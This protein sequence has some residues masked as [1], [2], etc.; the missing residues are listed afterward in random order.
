[1]KNNLL[2]NLLEK[3]S[4]EKHSPQLWILVDPDKSDRTKLQ[5]VAIAAQSAG[6]DCFL[7]GSSL[8][9]NS[10]IDETVAVLKANCEIPVLLFPGARTQLAKNADGIL[11]LTL[12]SSRNPRWLID[13]QV[14]AAPQVYRSC[15]PT[16]PVGYLLIESGEQTSVGFFSSTPPIPRAKADIAIAHSLAAQYMGMRAVY[17]EA[18]SGAKSPVPVEMLRAVAAKIDVPLIVGG[19]IRTLEDAVE[20][21][22][23]ADAI[24]IGNH[25]EN[26]D[27]ITEIG[28]FAKAVHSCK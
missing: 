24:V 1:M 8:L 27:N 23:Y 3:R 22:K 13:E 25:F 26:S 6:V 10:N 20:R 5:T 9:V 4:A 7:V 11:F 2:N 19:G 12:L 28:N 16:I 18:G 17:L 14:L 15:I 21:A